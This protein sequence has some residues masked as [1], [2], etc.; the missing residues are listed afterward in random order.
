MN[1]WD[2]ELLRDNPGSEPDEPEYLGYGPIITA[3]FDSPCDGT[4]MACDGLIRE[5]D[6]I[7]ADGDGGWVHRG[8]ES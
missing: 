3:G 6:D 1:D 4:H 5:G 2:Y 7:R 8:C